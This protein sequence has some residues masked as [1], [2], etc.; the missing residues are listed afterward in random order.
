MLIASSALLHVP[1]N[2]LSASLAFAAV[3]SGAGFVGAAYKGLAWPLLQSI[4]S[5]M[6]DICGDADDAAGREIVVV[7]SGT[8]AGDHR[9]NGTKEISA[10]NPTTNG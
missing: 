6:I 8:R 5:T 7:I 2:D 10:V 9:R 1:G 3:R 4:W